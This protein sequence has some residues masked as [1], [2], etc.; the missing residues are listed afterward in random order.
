MHSFVAGMAAGVFIVGMMP[1]LFWFDV[2][3]KGGRIKPVVVVPVI[4]TMV[5]SLMLAIAVDPFTA[6]FTLPTGVIFVVAVW[7]YVKW[8]YRKGPSTGKAL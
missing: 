3:R 6:K 5:C 1:V 4:A 8:K 7:L 2:L